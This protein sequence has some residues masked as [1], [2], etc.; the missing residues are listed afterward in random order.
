[1]SVSKK[2]VGVK[3][4][5]YVE[6]GM[7]VGFGTGSTA[8]YFTEEVGRR[9]QAGELP[10]IVGV[11]TSK[12][13][14]VQMQQLGIPV[15]SLD[16]IDRIDLLVDGAD[17]VTPEFNGIKGGGGALLLEKI[18]AQNSDKIIWIVDSAKLVDMLGKFPLPVEV[19]P[20]GA[21]KLFRVFEGAGMNP[22]FRKS[23]KDTL[24]ITDSGHYIID[25][26]LQA[27]QN[28]Q[29]LSFELNNMVGVVDHGL[30][31]NYPD[32]VL[33]GDEDGNINS[34]KR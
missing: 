34:I 16:D 30:F 13:T 21:W 6:D 28:P 31:L 10:H 2:N 17:E 8:Y 25:L 7:I 27:I 4:A 11:P 14:Q 22:T 18:V 32:L 23:G 1:M 9:F 20:F 33:V 19:V 15:R 24:F 26:H 3:A 5:S 29:Q 12:R